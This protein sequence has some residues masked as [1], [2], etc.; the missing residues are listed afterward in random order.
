MSEPSSIPATLLLLQDLDS[1]IDRIRHRREA[2]EERRKEREAA[3]AVDKA[4]EQKKRSAL[5]VATL[6][7][8]TGELDAAATEVRSRIESLNKRMFGSNVAARELSSLDAEVSA[9]GRRL[10]EIEDEELAAMEALEEAEARR[11]RY[12]SE[13]E[14][15]EATLAAAREEL[16]QA[17]AA[18]DAETAAVS[19]RRAP[20][21]ADLPAEVAAGY[22]ELRKRLGGVAVA[23]LEGRRCGGCHLD[24][25]AAEY[26][27]LRHARPEDLPT[28]ESCGRILLA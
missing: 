27:A 12:A 4:T 5:E 26:E 1:E 2:L 10:E 13:L 22:E 14:Q 19:S 28:C 23:K 7:S 6:R 18:L 25:S 8:R 24:L 9:L 17:E 15:A 3:A 11:K 21:V 20:L 16:S